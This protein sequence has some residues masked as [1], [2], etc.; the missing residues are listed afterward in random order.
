MAPATNAHA[1]ESRH[2]A[3][4]AASATA[5]ISATFSGEPADARDITSAATTPTAVTP[6]PA[7]MLSNRFSARET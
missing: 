7:R 1:G 3:A 4:G 5:A 2:A 6:R